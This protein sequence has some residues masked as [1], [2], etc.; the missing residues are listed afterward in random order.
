MATAMASAKASPTSPNFLCQRTLPVWINVTWEA[1][2]TSQ[3]KNTT[4][5]TWM[6]NG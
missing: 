6:I 5:W 1:R 4:A 2:K 3:P